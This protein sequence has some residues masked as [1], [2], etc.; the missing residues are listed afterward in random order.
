MP[1]WICTACERHVQPESTRCPFCDTELGTTS[2]PQR[3]MMVAAFGLALVGCGDRNGDATTA[4]DTEAAPTSDTTDTG[5]TMGMVSEGSSSTTA[6]DPDAGGE[7]Y[8]GPETDEWGEWETS[9]ST[10]EESGSTGGS[11]STGTDT[12][13]STGEMAEESGGQDYAGPEVDT[14]I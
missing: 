8:A 13:S 14:G 7:D 11:E 6:V 2:A 10:G 1:L 5:T 9:T 4:G 3:M 12:G